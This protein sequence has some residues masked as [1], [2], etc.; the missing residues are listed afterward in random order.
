[1]TFNW[2]GIGPNTHLEWGSEALGHRILSK[3]TKNCT[4]I[5]IFLT[6]VLNQPKFGNFWPGFV[7]TYCVCPRL[8]GDFISNKCD[9]SQLVT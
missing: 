6:S 1:M 7:S 2:G 9:I 3:S 8:C 4:E 5:R